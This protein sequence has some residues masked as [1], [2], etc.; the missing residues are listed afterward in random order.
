MEDTFSVVNLFSF[1]FWWKLT[2]KSYEENSTLINWEE[3]FLAT[4]NNIELEMKVVHHIQLLWDCETLKFT[5]LPKGQRIL[6]LKIAF[7]LPSKSMTW[8]LIFK[9]TDIV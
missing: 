5:Q 2:V 4:N 9:F 6:K 3:T 7:I 8:T 1:K